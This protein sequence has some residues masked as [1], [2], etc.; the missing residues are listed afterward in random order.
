MITLIIAGLQ[1]REGRHR[2]I[3]QL[4]EMGLKLD[5]LAP[6]PL[7]ALLLWGPPHCS[8][9]E[10][11]PSLAISG[12]LLGGHPRLS[13]VSL[14]AGLPP[15]GSDGWE[16]HAAAGPRAAPA[17]GGQPPYGPGEGSSHHPAPNPESCSEEP[18]HRLTKSLHF[19]ETEPHTWS[20]A[21][22]LQGSLAFWAECPNPAIL[23]GVP[24]GRQ[25][26]PVIPWQCQ[27]CS[28]VNG[29]RCPPAHGPLAGSFLT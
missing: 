15:T 24:S 2:E 20:R 1:V 28:P 19:Q 25:M 4:Q 21:D 17:R 11:A 16:H 29:A 9:S 7:L 26:T 8:H 13:Q 10:W 5:S 22:Q 6:E 3:K 12:G 18:G 14:R 23:A 27:L